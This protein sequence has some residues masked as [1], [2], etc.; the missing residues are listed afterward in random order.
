MNTSPTHDLI[1]NIMSL[2]FAIIIFDVVFRKYNIYNE[3]ADE[4]TPKTGSV[5]VP[6]QVYLFGKRAIALLFRLTR[7]DVLLTLK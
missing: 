2:N 5:R 6:L 7:P 4:R 3:I 1:I